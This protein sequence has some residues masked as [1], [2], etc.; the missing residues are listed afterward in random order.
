MVNE[1]FL[2]F[3]QLV[4]VE[5]SIIGSHLYWFSF[6]WYGENKHQRILQVYDRGVDEGL[7]YHIPHSVEKQAYGARGKAATCYW[8]QVQFP[9]GLIICCYSGGGKH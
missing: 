7:A 1:Q 5:E 3:R 6:D 4:L 8:I 2:P 9:E